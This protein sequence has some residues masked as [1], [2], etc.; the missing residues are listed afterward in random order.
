MVDDDDGI[1]GRQVQ[2]GKFCDA[3]RASHARMRLV[4]VFECGAS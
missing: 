3:I 2:D 1:V 4:V